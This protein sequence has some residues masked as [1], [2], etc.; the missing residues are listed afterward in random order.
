MVVRGGDRWDDRP[1]RRMAGHGCLP[2]CQTDIRLPEHADVA[3]TPRLRDEPFQG[4]VAILTFVH[5]GVKIPLGL[6]PAPDIL[7]ND[8]IATQH[9]AQ[10]D[11]NGDQTTLV[12][13]GA[14]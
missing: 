9:R 7:N 11:W 12:V 1:E 4:I 6:E 13:R 14:L 2:L 3:V 5:E 8:G 10:D